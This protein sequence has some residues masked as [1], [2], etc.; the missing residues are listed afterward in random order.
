[1]KSDIQ[2]TESYNNLDKQC[3][4]SYYYKKY[5]YIYL[6]LTWLTA[7]IWLALVSYII[8]TTL[9]KLSTDD[10]TVKLHLTVV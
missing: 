2:I 8:S 6:K 9:A 5:N 7:D 3:S 10:Y 1:M 4:Q